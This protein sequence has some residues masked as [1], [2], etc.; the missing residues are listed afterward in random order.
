MDFHC[1][2]IFRRNV[3]ISILAFALEN[4][5]T[6]VKYLV[7]IDDWIRRY[8]EQTNLQWYRTKI[9]VLNSLNK[10]I[11]I[12]RHFTSALNVLQG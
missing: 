7:M 4:S 3:R 6:F 1:G 9:T 2:Y 8:E 10:F 5:C 11:S 12:F